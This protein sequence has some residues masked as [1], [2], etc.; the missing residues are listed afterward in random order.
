MSSESTHGNGGARVISPVKLSH[1][2]LRTTRLKEMVEWYKTVLNAEALYEND[3]LAFM[4]YDEEHHR[5]A[6]AAVPGL[7]EKPKRSAGLDHLASFY[8]TV[9][10]WI[11]TYERLK[12]AGITPR[13]SIHHGLS[14]S[15]Y[16]RDPDDNGV[17]LS[18]DNVEKAKWH[19]YM[20]NTLKDN[21]IGAPMDPDELAAKYHA[22]APESE[23]R[24]FDPSPGKFDPEILRRMVE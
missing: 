15:L 19:D 18:I 17:E 23:I 21:P 6:L 2:V 9:G 7:V 5:I 20:R 11:S 16:Y 14:M 8:S 22:G 4:T 3:F 1:A 13:V 12:A 24:R 10:D